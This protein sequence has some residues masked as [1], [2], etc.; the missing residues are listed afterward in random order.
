MWNSYKIITQCLKAGQ[1]GYGHHKPAVQVWMLDCAR[2]GEREL[3][4]VQ[5]L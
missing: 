2:A 5:K 1:G 4:Q 3:K